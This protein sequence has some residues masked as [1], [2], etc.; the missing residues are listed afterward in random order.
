MKRAAMIDS[1]DEFFILSNLAPSEAQKRLALA[2][3]LA[4]LVMFVVAAGQLANIQPPVITAFIPAYTTAMCLSEMITAVFL[5]TQFA[6]LRSL[7][8]LVMSSGYLFTALIVIPYTL[9]FPGVFRSGSVI[10]GLQTRPF[11]Y[12]FWHAGFPLFVIA[13]AL[14]KDVAPS[15]RYWRG[16]V[17]SAITLSVGLTA[18]LVAAATAIFASANSTL[19]RVQVDIRHVGPNFLLL[20]VPTASLIIVALVVLWIRRRSILDLWLMVVLCAYQIEIWLDYYPF[21]GTFSFGWY[22]SRIFGLFSSSLVLLVLL[23]EIMTLY[24]R[25]LEAVRAQRRE[26]EA[27]LMTGD[28][29]AVAIAHEVKQPISGMVTSADAGLRFL[30]RGTPD[31][32]E[33]KEAFKQIVADGHRAGAVIGNIRAIFKKDG[34]NWAPFDLNGL[35][36]ETIVVVR[37]ELATNQISVKLELGERLPRTLGDRIQ[38]QQVLIN[39]IMNAI[40]SMA[41]VAGPRILL[42]T[43][44]LGDDGSIKVSVADTGAGVGEKNVDHIFNPLFTTKSNGMGMGLSICRSIVEA[45]NGELWVVPNKPCGAVFS[46]TSH[47]SAPA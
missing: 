2:V 19:P 17:S 21:P 28:A 46:F 1:G 6:N 33:A 27:R 8:L 14:I 38:L 10:G 13:Y 45:H 22:A 42:V 24:A 32:D 16:A 40:D 9:T 47:S 12:F 35:I 23:Y 41:A 39:L 20:G 36:D 5:F 29:V 43:S 34:R 7:A 37:D 3:V 26:R 31:L 18:A 25:L 44:E 11:I 15:K 4:L 30:E